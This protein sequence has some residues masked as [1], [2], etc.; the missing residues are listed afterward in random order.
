MGAVIAFPTR[1]RAGLSRRLW[2]LAAAGVSAVL[3]AVGGVML[4]GQDLLRSVRA[5]ALNEAPGRT[6]LSGAVVP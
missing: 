4:A 1:R 6:A 5:D 2:A 3:L